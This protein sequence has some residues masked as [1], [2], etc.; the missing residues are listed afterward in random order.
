MTVYGANPEQLAAL[1]T[2][3]KSQIEIISGLTKT[4][5]TALTGTTWTGPARDQF[6]EQWES[7]FRSALDGLAAAFNVAGGDCTR[8]AADLQVVMGRVS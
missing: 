1:G 4:V 3:L 5:T 8:R 7:T 6:Q 2:T